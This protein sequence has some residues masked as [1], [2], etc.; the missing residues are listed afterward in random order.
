MSLDLSL[1]QRVTVGPLTKGLPARGE[2]P[3]AEVGAQGW[4]LTDLPTP[5]MTLRR[6]AL[7]HNAGLMAEWCREHGVELAPHGKTSMAPQL[8]QLQLD[9]GGWAITAATAQQ[10]AVMAAVGV[11]RILIANQLVDPASL[12][13]LAEVTAGGETKV[14]CY[15]DSVAG[16]ELLDRA[17]ASSPQPLPV[18]VELGVFGGRTGART[19]AEAVAVA[20][21]VAKAPHLVL[22]GVAGYEGVICAERDQ[23]CLGHVRVF[24]SRLRSL[25]ELLL[26]RGAFDAAG[27][28]VVSAGG[29]AFFDVV[30]ATLGDGW[31]AAVPVRTVLRSGCYLTH[32]SGTYDRSSPLGRRSRRRRLRPALQAWGR[33]LS[34]PEADRAVISLGR[35]DVPF[36][37]GLPVPQRRYPGGDGEWE[38]LTGRVEVTRLNDQHAY[39]KL[40]D[41]VELQVGDLVG[42]GVSHPCTAFDKWRVIPL[43]D[44]QD[45]VVDAIATFF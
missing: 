18:L 40:D 32:D 37:A 11:P 24:C 28:A 12:R 38:A 23:E 6:S 43:L 7:V 13:W 35:R 22:A 29:S 45:R 8:W 2:I 1:L 17:L 14:L 15:V 41:D 30:A 26:Q 4:Q 31:S 34:R 39:L 9:Q 44:D 5:A 10:A 19:E 36:D 20:E 33:V 25:A 21:A 42:L 3:L 16:V 27:E